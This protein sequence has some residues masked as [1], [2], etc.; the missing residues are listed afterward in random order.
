MSAASRLLHGTDEPPIAGCPSCRTPLIS[1]MVYPGYEFICLECG[2]KC[3]FLAPIRLS[4]TPENEARL[5]ALQAEWDERQAA[6]V[7]PRSWKSG[8][9]KCQPMVDANYHQEHATEK[10]WVAD[11]AAR[12]WIASRAKRKAASS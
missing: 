2:R 9:P 4:P 3:S 7:I 11:A 1:T 8:C 12:E 10:E 6:L 5:E